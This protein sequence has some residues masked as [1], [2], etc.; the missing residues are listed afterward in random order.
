[1]EKLL[2]S[3]SGWKHI[4]NTIEKNYQFDNF[5]QAIAFINEVAGIAEAEN[6]HPDIQLWDWNNVK[7]TLT[8]HELKALSDKDF[9]VAA[10][11][12]QL[13]SR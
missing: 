2:E 12:D 4:G 10:K 1:M 5:R 6:H 11:I 8:T 3:I 9:K 13:K 7:L